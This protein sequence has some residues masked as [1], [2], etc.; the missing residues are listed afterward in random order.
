MMSYNTM[1]Y[2]TSP[3]VTRLIHLRDS[4][5]QTSTFEVLVLI[6]VVL[7]FTIRVIYT[8]SDFEGDN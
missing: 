5:I 8:Q 7:V 6:T 2:M 3:G 4:F 1:S